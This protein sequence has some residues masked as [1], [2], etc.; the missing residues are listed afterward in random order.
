[1]TCGLATRPAAGSPGGYVVG[2]LVHGHS[3][4]EWDQRPLEGNVT[5][6]VL[7]RIVT[8]N[9]TGK[10]V[11]QVMQIRRIAPGP[12]RSRMET[13]GPENRPG[14]RGL[15]DP[16]G[17][18][19]RVAGQFTDGNTRAVIRYVEQV[20]YD[21]DGNVQVIVTEHNGQQVRRLTGTTETLPDGGKRTRLEGNA[22]WPRPRQV[23][24]VYDFDAKGHLVRFDMGDEFTITRNE[25]GDVASFT[26][27]M[28]G[29]E[30]TVEFEYEYDPQGNWIR[31]EEY[32]FENGQRTRHAGRFRQITYAAAVAQAP[33]VKREDL[34]GVYE[35]RMG[36][37]EDPFH[38]VTRLELKADGTLRLT[39]NG[40]MRDTVIDKEATG[41]WSYEANAVFAQLEK[42]VKGPEIPPGFP[43]MWFGIS[44]DGKSLVGPDNKTRYQRVE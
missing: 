29:G 34:V 20:R 30:Q 43:A 3:I 18:L 19:V 33:V 14:A 40:K 26:R 38:L 37:P 36:K 25:R 9:R 7:G 15:I 2:P 5:E 6:V 10:T 12:G 41:K 16:H 31:Q 27:K 11:E 23:T 39:E 44:P 13:I 35:S 17:R 1:M 28:L 42:A 22:Q 21:A 32:R 4:W 8:D 24:L